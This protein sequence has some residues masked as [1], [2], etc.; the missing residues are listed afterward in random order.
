MVVNV[1]DTSRAYQVIQLLRENAP[2]HTNLMS[3]EA[4]CD[5][6]LN[7]QLDKFF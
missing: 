5:R 7:V 2:K 6:F 3:L 1:F 4:I